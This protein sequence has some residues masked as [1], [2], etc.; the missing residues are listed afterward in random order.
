METKGSLDILI[1]NAGVLE[2]G[3]IEATSMEQYDRVMNTNV[4]AIYQLTMLAVP[5]LVKTEGGSYDPLA[6]S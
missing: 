4:R 3:S 2:M 6:A 1:N 5:H